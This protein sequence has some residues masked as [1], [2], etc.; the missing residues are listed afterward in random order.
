VRYGTALAAFVGFLAFAALTAEAQEQPNSAGALAAYIAEADESY[1]WKPVSRYTHKGAAL[2]GLHLVS[3]K[4]R[5]TLWQHQLYLIRPDRIDSADHGMLIVGGGR[6]RE[7]AAFAVPEE[8]LREEIGPFVEIAKR[9]RAVVAVVGQVPFQPLFGMTEDRLIAYTLD[10]YLGTGDPEWPLLLPMVK[11][12]VRAMDAAQEAAASEWGLAL[13][14]FTVLGASKRGWTSW[15]T[16]AMDARVT[17]VV[18]IVIDAV[19]MRLHFAHEIEVWGSPSEEIQPYTDLNLHNILGSDEGRDLREIIDPYSYRDLLTQAKLIVVA[20]NDRYFPL[21]SLNLY[22]DAL[23]GRKYVLYVPNNGHD[24]ADLAYVVK[25]AAALNRDAAGLEQLPTIE[26]EFKRTN[27]DQ[28]LCVEAEP[29]PDRV[30][31]WAATAP[32]RDF[33]EARWEPREVRT[34][35]TDAGAANVVRLPLPESGYAAVFAELEF[36]RRR[37]AFSLT[38]NV[39]IFGTP[40]APSSTPIPRGTP[41]TCPPDAD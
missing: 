8:E 11:S 38:T 10:R 12:A 31:L 17:A 33:R 28:V 35:Q 7:S 23:I 2:V 3:Q 41:G 18:P 6:W 15:L 36:G 21:D 26:W 20:T 25:S 22:W 32:A 14:T 39:A 1:E 40:G 29:A 24:V 5:D 34:A 30:R 9:M 27:A 4:W 19:N 13:D 16:A 37:R